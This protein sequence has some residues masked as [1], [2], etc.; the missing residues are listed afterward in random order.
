M[1]LS[2][3]RGVP[4]KPARPAFEN[5]EAKSKFEIRDSRFEIRGLR[6]CVPRDTHVTAGPGA[7]LQCLSS[8]APAA[9]LALA[10]AQTPDAGRPCPVLTARCRSTPAKQSQFATPKRDE[11]GQRLRIHHSTPGSQSH[12]LAPTCSPDSRCKSGHVA[13]SQHTAISTPAR[14][15]ASPAIQERLFANPAVASISCSAIARR[16]V[17]PAALAPQREIV[18]IACSSLDPDRRFGSLNAPHLR[19][20]KPLR[21]DS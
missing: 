12:L 8:R 1:R 9:A 7:C 21:T 2:P 16:G 4:A 5:S 14:A 6:R 17:S 19:R 3:R 11:P 13:Y 10:I 15:H 18:P 20:A